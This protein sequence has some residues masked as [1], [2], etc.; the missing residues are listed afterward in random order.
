MNR[1][2]Y[3]KALRIGNLD[4]IA[5]GLDRG[6]DVNWQIEKGETALHKAVSVGQFDV[7]RLLLTRNANV[8]L[9]NS[10]L[11]TPL[12]IAVEKNQVEITGLLKSHG[13]QTFEE[14]IKKRESEIRQQAWASGFSWRTLKALAQD[15]V[16]T[17]EKFL[18]YLGFGRHSLS[19]WKE[20]EERQRELKIQKGLL[21][22]KE[23]LNEEEV[24]G[25]ARKNGHR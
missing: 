4:A 1:T 13:G 3:R 17:E 25:P 22:P 2:E 5:A 24:L 23:P 6:I 19:V 18:N 8:N 16:A 15:G 21:D 11:K 20:I 7:V 14:I 9:E 10:A 12:D